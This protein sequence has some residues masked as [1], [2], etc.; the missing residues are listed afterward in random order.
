MITIGCIGDPHIKS[1]N[2][3]ETNIAIDELIRVF[4]EDRC[5]IIVILGDILHNHDNFKLEPKCNADRFIMEMSKLSQ[6]LYILIGNHDRRN[7]S[8]FLT[9]IHAFNL[10]KTCNNITVVDD[11]IDET[12]RSRGETF[13]F[14]F[15]PFV[16]N[17]RFQ[18]A[19]ATKNIYPPFDKIDYFFLHQDV[20]GCKINKIAENEAIEWNPNYPSVISG[21]LHDRE[22]VYDNWDYVGSLMQSGHGDIKKKYILILKLSKNEPLKNEPPKNEP[23]KREFKFVSLNVPRRFVLNLTVNELEE[24]EVL[25]NCTLFIKVECTN[26]L[27]SKLLEL[28]NV[29]NMILNGAR[30]KNVDP[31]KLKYVSSGSDISTISDTKINFIDR[32]ENKIKSLEIPIITHIF[33]N[34]LKD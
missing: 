21:H 17:P 20:V 7:N 33:K 27:F 12:I 32:L 26:S 9:N 29:K 5:D 31:T 34:V 14:V 8:D 23:L 18:E 6:H 2:V 22:H 13:R 3:K 19:L 10:L 25:E 28:D 30:I 11:V 1:D 15:C 24:L 4:K 16:P